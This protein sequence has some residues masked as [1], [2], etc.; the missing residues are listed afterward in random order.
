MDLD[1][2]NQ[3]TLTKALEDGS[4]QLCPIMCEPG[5]TKEGAKGYILGNWNNLPT[6]F[7]EWLEGQ[8]YIPLWEDEWTT[9]SECGGLVRTQA[10]CWFWK[11][12]FI[13]REGEL[14][15]GKC[16]AGILP[17]YLESLEGKPAQ[18]LHINMKLDPTEYGYVKVN[19]ESFVAGLHPG[20]NVSP[21]TMSQKLKDAGVTRFLWCISDVEQF[22][23]YFDLYIHKGIQ[24]KLDLVR[25]LL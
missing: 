22:G 2:D 4:L 21:A 24:D 15:C 5:Y 1:Q 16:L 23:A 20:W 9:C 25:S 6:G 12:F 18:A 3:Q 10:D 7:F 11:P 8:D 17:S 14:L 19:N 13:T